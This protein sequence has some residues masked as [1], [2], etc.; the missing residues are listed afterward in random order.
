[1]IP[2]SILACCALCCALPAAALLTRADREDAE[3]LEIASRYGSSLALAAPAGE[4]VLIAPRWVLTAAHRA[5]ALQAPQSRIRIG[6]R[7]HEVA[8]VIAHPDAQPGN[9]ADIALVLLREA[10]AGVEPTPIYRGGEEKGKA[11]VVAAHGPTGRIGDPAPRPDGRKRASVNTIDALSERAFEA[12]I[13]QGDEASDLQGALTPEETGAP[14][15]IQLDDALFVAGIAVAADGA[16]ERYARI[17][18]FAD[19]I[20]RA[21]FRAAADEAAAATPAARK[22]T[23]R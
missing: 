13:K 10:V 16:R 20:D 8:A 5:R 22:P 6:D 2:R 9:A 14:A 4:G 19:W 15:Y 3:Y 11:I 18:A 12:R 7:A 21:M 17:S 1:M 23:R